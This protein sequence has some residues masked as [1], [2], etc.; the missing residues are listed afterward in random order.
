MK[1]ILSLAIL[2]LGM[3][4][5][6]SCVQVTRKTTRADKEVRYLKVANFDRLKL[7]CAYNVKYV[8]GDRWMVK[9]VGTSNAIA[10]MRFANKDGE[11][12]IYSE[13]RQYDFPDINTDYV[14]IYIMSPDLIGVSLLGAGNFKCEN[15]LDTDTLNLYLKGAGNLKFANIVADEV[16]GE[17][18][19]VG[20][21]TI[22]NL[23]SQQASFI[24]KGVGNTKVHINRCDRVECKLKGIGNM[25]LSGNVKQLD[26][27]A[28][29]LGKIDTDNLIV[30]SSHED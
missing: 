21:M 20:N 30:G 16:R 23:E 7:N 9:F 14:Q 19:G 25:K 11:L 15:T 12:H 24:L 5:M 8:Q 22:E 2:V 27:H 26:K 13:Q 18:K 1:K 4:C 6:G 3:V 10:D 29:G 28:N 17:M